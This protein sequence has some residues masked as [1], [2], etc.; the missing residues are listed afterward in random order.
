MSIENTTLALAGIFQC[1]E[2]VRQLA[3]KGMLDTTPFESSLHSLL[4][5]DAD[6]VEDVYGGV[7]GVKI[8]LQVLSGQLS[9]GDAEKMEVMHYVFGL[10][11]LERKLIKQDDMLTQIGEAILSAK[12]QVEIY[13]IS[14]PNVIAYLSNLYTQTLSTFNFRIKVNGERNFLENQQNAEKIRAL[15]LAGVRSA[16]LWR[17]KG[18]RRFQ[19][20]LSRKRIVNTA[21][22][23]LEHM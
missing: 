2:L 1:A 18:G 6:S 23:Y 20:L 3:R 22:H 21:K 9:A 12:A 10:I 13:N 11:I 8:G 7:P 15:L 5:L 4:K 19:F 17:Q 14:H 16:M